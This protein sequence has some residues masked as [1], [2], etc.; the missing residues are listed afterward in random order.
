MKNLE[1]YK[2]LKLQRISEYPYLAIQFTT[3]RQT[4]HRRYATD[5]KGNRQGDKLTI[6]Q[7]KRWTD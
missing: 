1:L 7:T 4:I 6:K 2:W 3:T 5:K